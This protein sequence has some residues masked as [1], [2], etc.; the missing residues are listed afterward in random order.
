MMMPL[1][2]TFHKCFEFSSIKF[3]PLRKN[4]CSAPPKTGFIEGNVIQDG[5]HFEK[6][7]RHFDARFFTDDVGK[8]NGT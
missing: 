4:Y 3:I 5:G 7:G 8:K 2:Q 6:N 1:Q